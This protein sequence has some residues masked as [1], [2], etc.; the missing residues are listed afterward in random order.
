MEDDSQ[1]RCTA[2]D[3]QLDTPLANGAFPAGDPDDAEDDDPAESNDD[4]ESESWS[5]PRWQVAS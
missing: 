5:E 4:A 1:D 2:L 3:D